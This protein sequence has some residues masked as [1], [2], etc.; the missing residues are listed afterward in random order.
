MFNIA[1]YR[2][3]KKPLSDYLPWAMFIKEGVLLN[4]DGSFQKIYRFRGP[5]LDSSTKTEFVA[6]RARFNNVIKQLGSNWCIHFEARRRKSKTYY[7]SNFENEAAAYFDLERQQNFEQEKNQY[8]TD[9]YL[10]LTCLTPE[11]TKGKLETVFYEN[12]PKLKASDYKRYLDEF[13][14]ICD[15][16]GDSLE[17]FMPRFVALDDAQTLTY[18]HD[19]I[20]NRNV[21]MQAPEVPMYI[22]ALITDTSLACGRHPK[23]GDEYMDI[24]SFRGCLL[25]TS[26]AADE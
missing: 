10:S 19:C 18:L 6:A 1:E 5:D 25:Y 21:E 4:K 3:S 12:L 23:L 20:S 8:E 16:I 2:N 11:D 14:A 22:D 17:V 15:K 7:K 24:I 9:Y 13:E 26:D